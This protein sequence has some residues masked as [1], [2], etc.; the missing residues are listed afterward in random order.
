[1][2]PFGPFYSL[3]RP[4]L[5]ALWEWQQE[6]LSEGV[7]HA[8]QSPAGSPILLVKKSDGS[9]RLCVDYRVLNQGT[10]KNR[11]PLPLV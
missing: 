3:S 4:E 1:M 2:P 8:S 5:E 10:I 9:L 11:Y 7:I 6:N